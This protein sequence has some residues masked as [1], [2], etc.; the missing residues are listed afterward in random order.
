MLTILYPENDYTS[1][2]IAIRTQALAQGQGQK[3]YVV[4]KHYGRN[5]GNVFKNLSKT[6][7]V[8]FISYDK[9][10]LDEN[11]EKE[12][13][14]LLQNGKKIHAIIPE[15]MSQSHLPVSKVNIYSY[16]QSN[17]INFSQAI[18]DF[19]VKSK[20]PKEKKSKSNDLLMLVGVL[21]LSILVLSLINNNPNGEK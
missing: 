19:I 17:K 16:A 1:A 15:A 8:L 20:V 7:A 3:I 12:I 9:I 6:D 14:Y 2:D 13:D 18:E 5:E 11:T 10:K 21:L 4:P